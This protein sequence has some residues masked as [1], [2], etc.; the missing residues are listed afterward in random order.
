MATWRWTGDVIIGANG[1]LFKTGTGDPQGVVTANPGSLY[2]RTDAT[3]G[4]SI[5]IKETGTGNTGWV[6]LITG[7]TTALQIQ[8]NGVN[9]SLQDLLNLTGTGLTITDEGSGN[10][11]LDVEVTTVPY[12]NLNGTITTVGQ[13]LDAL[14][15][16]QIQNLTNNVLVQEVGSTLSS[17]NVTWSLSDAASDL[18]FIAIPATFAPS[19]PAVISPTTSTAQ[20]FL[21]GFTSSSQSTITWTLQATKGTQIV[22]SNTSVSFQLKNYFGASALTSL[23]S[24]DVVAL[25]GS[26]QSSKVQTITYNC[27]GGK[28]PYFAYP[29]AYGDPTR[30]TVGGIDFTDYTVSTV[31][32]TNASG[33]TVNYKVVKFNVLQTGILTV[34]WS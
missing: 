15:P 17:V 20:T 16:L 14:L 22:T 26:F 21:G 27:T 31:L 33:Y 10:V 19:A 13:A 30:V 28:Y 23:T 18:R 34:S 24:S 25:G 9:T 2:L 1:Q 6:A 12:S 4:Q 5:Y 8:V 11:N 29:F 32:V 7:G 3:P